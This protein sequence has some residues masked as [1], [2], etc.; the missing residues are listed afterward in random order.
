[1][2]KKSFRIC[3]I[4]NAVTNNFV[5]TYIELNIC[6]QNRC[7]HKRKR[8]MLET[9]CVDG[10]NILLVTVL[11]ILVT[12]NKQMSSTIS[13][14]HRHDNVAKITGLQSC[15]W[16]CDIGDLKIVTIWEYWRQNR[17]L[18]NVFWKLVLVAYVKR[19]RM[20]VTKIP[21]MWG[22]KSVTNIIKLSSIHFVSNIRQQNRCSH[23]TVTICIRVTENIIGF[24]D[25]KFK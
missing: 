11:T 12:N 22:A 2:L 6:P 5:L 19:F 18:V 24:K 17:H 8:R 14:T 16:H 7:S 9:K 10:N 23:I 25:F 4:Q 20:W 21:R 1:M 15:W 13:F 3:K